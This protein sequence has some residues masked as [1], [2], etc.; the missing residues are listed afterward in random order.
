MLWQIL[1]VFGTG[2]A[3]VISPVERI[4]F[5]HDVYDIPIDPSQG[6]GPLARSLLEELND[7]QVKVK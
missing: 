1:E 2:T 7:I 4:G 5:R 6:I 3:A